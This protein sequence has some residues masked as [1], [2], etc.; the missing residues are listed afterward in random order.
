ML[1]QGLVGGVASGESSFEE[2]GRSSPELAV[3]RFEN[4]ELAKGSDGKSVE[5][6]VA[7]WA[8]LTRRSTLICDAP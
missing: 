5:L 1:R 8:S 7:R 3:Q 6:V 4:Y 2:A